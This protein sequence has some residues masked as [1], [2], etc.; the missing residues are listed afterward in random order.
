MKKALPALA[1]ALTAALLAPSAGHAALTVYAGYWDTADLGEDFGLGAR[2][3]LPLAPRI[4]LEFGAAYYEQLDRTVE[5]G[6]QPVEVEV[7]ARVIPLDVGLRLDIGRRGG[8]YFGGGASYLLLDSD[9]GDLG[10]EFGW[11][12]S[13]GFMLGR[14]LF[15]EGVY[16]QVEG[17]VDLRDGVFPDPQVLPGFDVDLTGVAINV[18]FRF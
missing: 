8:F 15:V 9:A 11:Y 16:R 13:L 18:G 4:Q 1:F 17:T 7:D 6:G 2:F 14:T 5:V 3:G 10:D 12:G